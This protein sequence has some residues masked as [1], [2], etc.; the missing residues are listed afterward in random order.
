MSEIEIRKTCEYDDF[1]HFCLEELKEF[2][3]E[4]LPGLLE[5]DFS[6]FVGEAEVDGYN[7][8]TLICNGTP[9]EHDPTEIPEY[10]AA[11]FGMQGDF[12]IIGSLLKRGDSLYGGVG[13]GFLFAIP[14][15]FIVHKY[16]DLIN[17]LYQ[18]LFSVGP[19]IGVNAIYGASDKDT[20][21]V[22]FM[23]G[24][25]HSM[26]GSKNVGYKLSFG[27]IMDK[28]MFGN[29]KDHGLYVGMDFLF[30]KIAGRVV[31]RAAFTCGLGALLAYFPK[32]RDLNT[33]ARTFLGFLY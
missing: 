30:S 5:S 19:E 29:E 12:N 25:R 32:D 13:G 21:S 16:G 7:T 11:K 6:C 9:K 3:V 28:L 10:N 26:V 31:N 8:V 23:A 1:K 27:Y 20:S 14:M 24:A 4:V 17:P 18:A 33:M 22:Q 2:Q 15:N